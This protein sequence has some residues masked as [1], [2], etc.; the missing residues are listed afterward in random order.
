MTKVALIL[1]LLFSINSMA[2]SEHSICNYGDAHAVDAFDD[3]YNCNEGV[4]LIGAVKTEKGA[5]YIADCTADSL[6][7]MQVSLNLS[8]E[9]LSSIFK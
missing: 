2:S 8:C 6:G 7:T 1:S 5:A 4:E 9:P 3:T